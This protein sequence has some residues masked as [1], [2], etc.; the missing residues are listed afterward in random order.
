[1]TQARWRAA[2]M[3]FGEFRVIDRMQYKTELTDAEEDLVK[4]TKEALS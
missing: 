2:Y 4:E 3:Q 1:M